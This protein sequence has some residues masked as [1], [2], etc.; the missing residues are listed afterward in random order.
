SLM[1]AF[2]GGRFRS[3]VAAKPES[4]GHAAGAVPLLG[5]V[6]RAEPDAAVIAWPVAGGCGR[7]DGHAADRVGGLL[8]QVPVGVGTEA[9]GAPGA[10]EANCPALVL[11]LGGRIRGVDGH[12]AHRVKGR[13]VHSVAG[14]VVVAVG[15]LRDE[16]GGG[17]AVRVGR[18]AVGTVFG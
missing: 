18:E 1:A 15:F 17:V 5:A 2:G 9:L 16:S 6:G 8:G 13:E 11:D 7:G 14:S 12:A 3:S 10:A 4:H